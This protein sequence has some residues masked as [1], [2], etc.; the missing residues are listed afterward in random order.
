MKRGYLLAV[1]VA[2]VVFAV[3]LAGCPHRQ[4]GMPE[5]AP[6]PGNMMKG[7]GG[8]GGPGMGGNEMPPAETNAPA[9][10]GNEVPVDNMASSAEI[11]PSASAN[12]AGETKIPPP[13]ESGKGKKKP[14]KG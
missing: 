12:A 4:G 14:K 8:M 13:A 11:P 7:P 1:V 6:G 10:E 9:A 5:G 2:V 3:M